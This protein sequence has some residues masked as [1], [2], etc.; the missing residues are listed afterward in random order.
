MSCYY[1]VGPKD[2]GTLGSCRIPKLIPNETDP[3]YKKCITN[4]LL[5]RLSRFHKLH[6]IFSMCWFWWIQGLGPGPGPNNLRGPLVRVLPAPILGPRVRAQALDSQHKKI[7]QN[8][9]P[10]ISRSAYLSVK[11]SIY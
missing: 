1:G 2:Q 11:Q 6:S 3:K 9:V 7:P 10:F 4:L 5:N 8:I